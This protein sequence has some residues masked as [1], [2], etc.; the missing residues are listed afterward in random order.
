MKID[1][2]LAYFARVVLAVLII[3]GT[4]I[5][6]AAAHEVRRISANGTVLA[7][8][9]LGQGEP[10]IF[11][12]GGLQDYRM[13]LKHIAVFL[14]PSMAACDWRANFHVLRDNVGLRETT[15]SICHRVS[16]VDNCCRTR[17]TASFV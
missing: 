2:Y 10:V 14:K 15:P 1:T 12:H 7:Y 3:S 13:W 17:P 9:E 8:I 5:T 6:V 11:V 4:M 16:V